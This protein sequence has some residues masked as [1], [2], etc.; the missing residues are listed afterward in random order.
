[1]LALV[2]RFDLRPDGVEGFDS[3]V[4]RALPLIREL[5]PGTLVYAAHAVQGEPTA[6]V[7]YEVYADRAAFEAHEQ[8]PHVVEMLTRIREHLSREPRV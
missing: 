6:R 2:V 3:L 7:F 4:A 1:M 8:Q 5:E